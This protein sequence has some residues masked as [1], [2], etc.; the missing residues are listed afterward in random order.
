[1]RALAIVKPTSAVPPP[2]MV[3]RLTEGFAAWRAQWKPYMESFYFFASNQGGCGVFNAPDEATLHTICATFPLAFFSTI[4]LLPVVDG[5][6]ALA[7]FTD[8]AKQ[9]LARMG[10]GD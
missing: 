9:M 1:M 2:E 8:I 10:S 5:D 6:E 7:R 3:I 4:E